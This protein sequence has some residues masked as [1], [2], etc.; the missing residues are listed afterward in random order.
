MARTPGAKNKNKF[1]SVSLADILKVFTLDTKIPVETTWAKIIKDSISQGVSA[2]VS[3][4]T[5]NSIVQ[6]TT[7]GVPAV[8]VVDPTIKIEDLSHYRCE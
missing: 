3:A 7:P 4:A 5:A 2:P 6:P 8:P 1:E